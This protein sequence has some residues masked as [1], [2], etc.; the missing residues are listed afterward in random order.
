MMKC[1][2]Q[3]FS[4]LPIKQ[5]FHQK[6]A[7]EYIKKLPTVKNFRLLPVHG[8]G[9]WYV[10]ANGEIVKKEILPKNFSLTKSL[11]FSWKLSNYK[12][13]ASHKYTR[14]PWRVAR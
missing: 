5:V 10:G 9:A 13:F 3:H 6:A 8:K 2:Q 14:G 4:I 12:C 1:L 11:D 7:S